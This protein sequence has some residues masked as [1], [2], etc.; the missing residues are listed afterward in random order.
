V[1]QLVEQYALQEA[2]ELTGAVPQEHLKEYLSR[3]DV[4]VLP[5]IT[6]SNG[7]MDGIPVSLM[8]AMAIEIP[9][10]STYVSGIPELIED[11]QNGLLVSEKDEVA[12]ANALQRLLEDEVLRTK[13]GKDGRQK[14]MHEFNIHKNAAQL[15]TLFERYVS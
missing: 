3:A 1:E 8:E 15:A 12:L 5:C 7:D 14:V 4:F 10:V 13:L 9:T 11:G 6:A 2:I